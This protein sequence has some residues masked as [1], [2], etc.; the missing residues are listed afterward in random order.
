MPIKTHTAST[1]RRSRNA[2]IA[3]TRRSAPAD[4]PAGWIV[5]YYIGHDVIKVDG[6]YL[7]QP[8]TGFFNTEK[9]AQHF[10][11]YMRRRYKSAR[12]IRIAAHPD[13]CLDGEPAFEQV[14]H[15]KALRKAEEARS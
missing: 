6:R 3:S 11:P 5:R 15:V 1:T 4:A 9:G 10:L 7:G 8:L 13:Y 14:E 2:S 12:V